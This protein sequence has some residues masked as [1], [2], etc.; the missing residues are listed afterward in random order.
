[1]NESEKLFERVPR[2]VPV[3]VNSPAWN[4]RARAERPP[5]S[6]QGRRPLGN[7]LTIYSCG[8]I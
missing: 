2:L 1:M 3:S 8:D 4:I 7:T 6:S 5:V